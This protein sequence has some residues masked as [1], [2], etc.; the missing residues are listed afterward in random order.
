MLVLRGTD[1]GGKQSITRVLISVL[2]VKKPPE[3]KRDNYET[4]INENSAVGTKAIDIRADYDGTALLKYFFIAG[5]SDNNF[6]IDHLGVI[7]VGQPLDRE[8]VPSYELTVM[9][10]LENKN[11]TAKVKII[12]S[13]ANDDRPSFENP[14]FTIEVP[15]DQG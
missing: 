15:E 7:S 8:K 9:V 2:N 6:C 5:N 11:D 14:V 1:G 3:F 13:D 4:V 10:S 12:L